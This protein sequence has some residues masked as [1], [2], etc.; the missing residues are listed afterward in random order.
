MIKALIE[1]A[2]EKAQAD[3]DAPLTDSLAFLAQ[4][5]SNIVHEND[6]LYFIVSLFRFQMTPVY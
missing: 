2:A 4:D 6:L 5:F 3:S 1:Y